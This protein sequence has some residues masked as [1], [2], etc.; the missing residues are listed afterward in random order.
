MLLLTEAAEAAIKSG[1][2]KGIYEVYGRNCAG[3]YL[4]IA[5]SR[6]GEQDVVFHMGAMSPREKHWYGSYEAGTSEEEDSRDA[7]AAPGRKL[8]LNSTISSTVT[9]ASTCWTGGSRRWIPI[10]RIWTGCCSNIGASPTRS[11]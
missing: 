1:A 2:S 4:R 3:E 6:D 8:T 9:M 10:V 7:P 11:S 5:Y